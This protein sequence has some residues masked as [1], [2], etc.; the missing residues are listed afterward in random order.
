MSH[1]IETIDFKF[2]LLD[3]ENFSAQFVSYMFWKVQVSFR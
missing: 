1:G 3:I 2:W